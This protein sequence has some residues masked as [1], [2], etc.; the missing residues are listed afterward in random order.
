MNLDNPVTFYNA[1]PKE[2]AA[3]IKFRTE[4]HKALAGDKSMQKAY[5]DLIRQDPKIAY[6]SLLWTFNPRLPSGFRNR[7]FILWPGQEPAVDM[8]HKGHHDR[9]DIAVHKSRDEGATELI[10]AYLNILFLLDEQMVALVGSEKADKVDKSV[11]VD[12]DYHLSGEF[13]C[14][15]YK[16]CYGLVTLPQW[17]RPKIVKSYMHLE[18][19]ENGAGIDG[20]STNPNFGLSKRCDV[21]LLDEIGCVDHET[22]E[23][24]ISNI[25]DVCDF[26]IFN[27][28]HHWGPGHPYDK[29]L[30]ND[31]I[32]VV[33]L[34]WHQNPKKVVGLYETPEIGVVSIKDMGYYKTRWPQF[35]ENIE[36][37]KPF[38]IESWKESL[39]IKYPEQLEKLEEFS[40]IA[41]GGIQFGKLRSVWFD[42]EVKRRGNS[43]SDI[44][45]NILGEAGGSGKMTFTH[46]TLEL[47]KRLTV[48]EPLYSGEIE[49]TLDKDGHVAKSK[50]STGFPEGRM[51]WWGRLV[52][53]RPNPNHKF[54]LAIDPSRGT[55]AANAVVGIYDVNTNDEVGKW[56]CPNT[57]EERLADVVWAIRKWVH[58]N[59]N[60]VYIIWEANGAG[61]FENKIIWH[62]CTN[63]YAPRPERARIHKKKQNK[64]GW[65]S[66]TTLKHDLLRE[67][68][69]AMGCGLQKVPTYKYIII[70]DA[71]TIKEMESY[72]E[73]SSGLDC[74]S[75]LVKESN[76][77]RAAHGDRVIPPAL[78]VL[79]RKYV[80]PAEIIQADQTLNKNSIGA[81]I[82][83][84]KLAQR[85]ESLK[86]FPFA[87]I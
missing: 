10:R 59:P 1:I 25:A 78:Y 31:D 87:G 11:Q 53:G 45:Q 38:R 68:D 39:K 32:H 44:Y 84:F 40:F 28:T 80:T 54:V 18:N 46:D 37:Q 8:F 64:R 26:N 4:L 58:D 24:I 23:T 20:E 14:L 83:A 48:F 55:G 27:S 30:H 62:G 22:A 73:S 7:P 71:L 29:L 42:K 3:N 49:Y 17:I 74:P 85:K 50:F 41:D 65:W 56:V 79:A 15:M 2:I 67:L 57:P 13:G 34:L 33:K 6:N 69:V 5:L 77:A 43:I 47:A 16:L 86:R 82:E 81:R 9:F 12:K 61:A 35:F 52:D 75:H 76:G 19:L 70:H 21:T 60:Y 63:Y 72:I 66:N 36:P 51:K